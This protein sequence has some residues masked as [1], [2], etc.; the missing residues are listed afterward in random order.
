MLE[1]A[2][3]GIVGALATGARAARAPL[4]A[5]MD[6]DDVSLPERF[7]RQLA[8]LD[9]HPDVAAVG[10]AVE[11]LADAEVGEGLVRYVA[12]QNGLITP[13]DHD[14]AIFVESPLCHPSVM[15]RR[16][17]YESVGG[18]REM[19][20]F[21]DYDLWLRLWAAGHRFAKLPEVLL[22]WR[23]RVGRLTT[24]DPRASEDAFLTAKATFL[25]PWI[26]ERKRPLTVWGGGKVGRRLARALE[27]HGVAA[28]RF[29]DIDPKKI[30]RVARG[31]PIVSP[32]SLRVG[33][34]T[35]IA[36]VGTRGART[37]IR[38]A[39]DARG[40]IECVDYRVAA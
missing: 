18:Y 7:S 28:A 22:Q 25:A 38:S 33:E 29:V 35:V 36:S 6:A 16:A 23:H 27:A 31:V 34:E 13:D 9:A 21:E 4:F 10:T 14:R 2:R 40:F 32:D 37:L 17:A 5:R 12:W 39:L 20:W 19:P 8:Y 3:P 1:A 15:L 30:G 11:N 26:R 24:T